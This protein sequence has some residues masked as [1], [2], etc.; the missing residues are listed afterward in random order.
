METVTHDATKVSEYSPTEAA[1][2]TL[3]DKYAGATFPVATKEGMRAA[4]AA[5][6]E[7][8]KLRTALEA[9]RV[10]IKAP[11]LKQT[12]LIDDEA[13]RITGE[14]LK[15]EE[16]IDRLIQAEE[17]KQEEARQAAIRAEQER[18]AEIRK[19]ITDISSVP[20]RL[21]GKPAG[22]LSIAIDDL[23]ADPLTWA[24]EHIDDA[25]LVT[26]TAVA[27][28][29]QM[30]TAALAAVAEAKRL[31]AERERIAAE[32]AELARQQAAQREAEEKA[33][34]DREEAERQARAKIEAEERAAR[35]RIEAAERERQAKIAAE[36]EER[37][38]QRQ[39][40]EE[41]IRAEQEKLAR[42]RAELERERLEKE[43]A[44]RREQEERERKA[45]EEAEAA[46][47]AKAD[48][49]RRQREA[50]EAEE[51]ARRQEEA[52]RLEA[53]QMLRTFVQRFGHLQEFKGVASG[54][55]VFLTDIPEVPQR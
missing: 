27:Q 48:E 39:A 36:E 15:L 6:F 5:R 20:V 45:R 23:K 35:E 49:E 32:Q 42:E 54:I 50:A 12:R 44:A 11:L 47:R 17:Q 41:R 18:V 28:L 4:K 9:K 13:K 8:V 25:K 3:R 31:A 2:A 52:D 26:A 7:L 55:V 22:D 1:L 40:E 46:A 33:R 51:R 24:Q 53:R 16:P 14:L 10:E 29:E 43:L 34:R 38:R 21:A 37:R 19:R 30:H